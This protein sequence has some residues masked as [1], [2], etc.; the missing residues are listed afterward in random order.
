M[1]RGIGRRAL[2]FWIASLVCVALVPP[3]PGDL[4]WVAWVTAGI[5][6]FWAILLTIEDL[7]GP[8]SRAEGPTGL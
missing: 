5:G 4:R 7:V 1:R 2:F 8:E 6:V 3:A